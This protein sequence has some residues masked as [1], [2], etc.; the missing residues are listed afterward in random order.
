MTILITG[1]EGQLGKSL[2][3]TSEENKGILGLN[4]N[5]FNL[6]DYNHCKDVILNKKPKW[7]INTAAFTDVNRA[8]IEQE[9]AF[10]VNS[11]GIANI[12]KVASTYG[13]K[14][15]HISS[16]YVFDGNNSNSYKPTDKCNPLNIYGSSKFKGEQLIKEHPNIIIL[17]TS[18]LYGPYGKNFCLTILKMYK[19]FAK[20][21]KPIKVIND[22]IGCPTSSI[23][24]AEIC[25]KFVSHFNKKNFSNEIFHWCNSGVTNWYDFAKTIVDLGF[26]Y[27]LLTN[28]V[29]V[30]PINSQQY[31]S[32]AK[33]PKFSLLD[34]EKT[35][36][37]L[38]IDQRYW[39]NS[40]RDVIK[41]AKIE[42]L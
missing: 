14:I 39:K 25:W 42:D 41:S 2:I 23:D 21:K 5:E 16:D 9:K 12:A 11:L 6:E 35:R 26:E 18:W 22:Q 8:E 15:V 17:R 40:L 34:C 1:I 27:G 30:L 10:K 29:D 4:K 38:K 13:G 32:K 19:L 28:R 33:R 36:K 24:L 31:K 3:D 37:L 7:I 20:E